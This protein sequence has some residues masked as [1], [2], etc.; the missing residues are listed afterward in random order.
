MKQQD[1]SLEKFF[2]ERYES[3]E[4]D[5]T[6]AD[7]LWDRIAEQQK[8]DRKFVFWLLPLVGAISIVG[9]LWFSS[10][11]VQPSF[12]LTETNSEYIEEPKETEHSKSSVDNQLELV[13]SPN[14]EVLQKQPIAIRATTS[15]TTLEVPKTQQEDRVKDTSISSITSLL[16][17]S[18]NVDKKKDPVVANF[19]SKL[20][21]QILSKFQSQPETQVEAEFQPTSILQESL[22]LKSLSPLSLVFPTEHLVF[23]RMNVNLVKPHIPFKRS[24]HLKASLIVSQPFDRIDAIDKSMVSAEVF[25]ALHQQHFSVLVGAG[26]RVEGLYNLSSHFGIS[27]GVELYQ[28][29]T[30]FQSAQ[31]DFNRVLIENPDAFFIVDEF[32]NRTSIAELIYGREAIVTTTYQTVKENYL[33]VPLGIY[34]DTP[35]SNRLSFRAKGETIFNFGSSYR[36]QFLNES[37]G[38]M[39]SMEEDSGLNFIQRLEYSASI[40]LGYQVS[41]RF[42]LSFQPM[43][44]YRPQLRSADLI[45]HSR[46]QIGSSF[47][48]QYRLGN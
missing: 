26:A 6:G 12:S 41:E 36:G 35:L 16:V 21:S 29:R 33:N 39:E 42:L 14:N 9:W 23:E 45:G 11:D 47:G 44:R 37:L 27:L 1:K 20:S 32:G 7:Q 5:M 13:V 15:T 30:Q 2:A 18:K 25:K 4:F 8:P 3:K 10:T 22:G 17:D 31:L 28:V 40:A 43:V 24:F 48:L 19:E 38:F 46:L 34:F